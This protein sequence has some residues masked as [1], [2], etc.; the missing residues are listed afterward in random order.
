MSRAY[1]CAQA[2]A[3]WDTAGDIRR[4]AVIA[5]TRQALIGSDLA[6]IHG[7]KREQDPTLPEFNAL[8]ASELL[9]L[10]TEADTVVVVAATDYDIA[11]ASNPYGPGIS[12]RS[13]WYE[14]SLLQRMNFFP[15]S[16]LDD[17]GARQLHASWLLTRG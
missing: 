5:G 16:S 3:E 17:P 9:D 2:A 8:T 10:Q 7:A 14:R 15:E 13:S 1:I 11:L 12:L 4:S 6:T